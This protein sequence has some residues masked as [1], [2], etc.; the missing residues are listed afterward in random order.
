MTGG[1]IKRTKPPQEWNFYGYIRRRRCW[2]WPQWLVKLLVH[3]EN[4]SRH[5]RATTGSFRWA[6]FNDSTVNFSEK[7]AGACRLD[8]WWFLGFW[9]KLFDYLSDDSG[10]LGLMHSNNSP[11]VSSL[12]FRHQFWQCMDTL[13]DKR[14]LKPLGKPKR[15]GKFGKYRDRK[16]VLIT[17]HEL[18]ESSPFG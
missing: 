12:P 7:T 8:K 11:K 6:T 5:C 13:R 9:A 18:K 16:K 4:N 2:R 17:G 1:R 15:N 3:T 10:I 14:N